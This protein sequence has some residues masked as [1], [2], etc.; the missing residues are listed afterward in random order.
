MGNEGNKTGSSASG[1][2]PME[3]VMER[4]VTNFL[5]ALQTSITNGTLERREEPTMIKQFQD[6]KPTTFIGSPNPLVAEAWVRDMEK[7]FRALP[8]IERQKVTFATFIFKDDAREWWLLTLEKENIVIWARFLEVFYEKCFPDSLREQKVLEFIHI[9][10]G[11]MTVTEN[12]SKFTQL[13][14]FAT[15]VIPNEARKARKF[16]A[17]LDP[18]IKDRLEV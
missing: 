16:E 4:T 1:T 11:T 14:R 15:Y 3:Q 5:Q 17:G 12:E 2:I 6:Q 18:E 10:Q 8:C 13:T 7:I 9:R